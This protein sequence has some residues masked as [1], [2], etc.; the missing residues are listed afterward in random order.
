MAS[1][2]SFPNM[3]DASSGKVVTVSKEVSYRQSLKSALLTSLGELLGDP[4]F[5]CDLKSVMFEIKS[6]LV[7]Q[8]IKETVA[9]TARK[10]VPQLTILS[11]DIN[12]N[13]D[14]VSYA[15]IVINY[16]TIDTGETNFIELIVQSDGSL[17]T[18]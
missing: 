8:L 18:R 4:I 14:H 12:I 6:T 16:Y 9:T 3:F 17:T 5:G 10:F 1:T 13:E 2:I 7:Q 11:T 15:P